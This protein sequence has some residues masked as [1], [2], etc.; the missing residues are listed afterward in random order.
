MI[1][2]EMTL[3]GA[4]IIE[5]EKREDERG[6]FAR[7]YCQQEFEAYH[8]SLKVVQA[9]IS[10]NKVKGTL[11]G[12]HYQQAPYAEIKIVRCTR[13]ALYDV[14]IDLRPDSPTYKQWSSVE[15]TAD[16]YKTLYIPEGFAHGFMTLEDKTEVSYQVSQF[17]TPGA[18][19][20]VRY[21]DPTFGIHW[22]MAVRVMSAKDHSWPD[23]VE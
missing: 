13:G 2:Q 1:F 14:I 12:M 17:Y 9:N 19:G 18:E 3:K 15:L 6:F 5:L 22:P 10:F 20:G 7:S 16:N 8:L 23:F 4:Y 21:N 11:R